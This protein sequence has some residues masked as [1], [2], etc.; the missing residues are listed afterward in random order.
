MINWQ[1]QY[2][3]FAPN[4]HNG[5][6]HVD[7]GEFGT[8]ELLPGPG[9]GDYSHPTTRLTLKLMSVKDKSVLDIGCGSGIL[10]IAAMKMGAKSAHGIDI[11]LDAIAHAKENAKLNNV[12]VSFSKK[13]VQSDVI[14]MNMIFSEQK[15]AYQSG[16]KEMI[17]SGI[18]ESQKDSYVQWVNSLG[19]D[20]V[21]VTQEEEWLGFRWKSR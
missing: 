6:A 20:L 19:W 21:E 2:Q 9:F 17:T 15:V 16:A 10:S 13:S 5:K 14:L 12:K 11:D 18:L 7:L 8:L 1:H 4:F 3:L